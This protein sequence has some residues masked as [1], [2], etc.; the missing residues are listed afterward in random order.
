MSELIEQDDS[1]TP[2]FQ[3]LLA[4]AETH[5]HQFR[6]KETEQLQREGKLEEVLM[7]RT[8]LCWDSLKACRKAGMNMVEAQEIAF[9]YILLPDEDDDTEYPA[10]GPQW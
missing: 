9:P 8:Q 3:N 1:T 2:A 10:G 7:L 4:K 6:P 5:Q